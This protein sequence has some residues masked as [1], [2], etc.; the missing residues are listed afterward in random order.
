MLVILIDD[1]GFGASSAFGGPCHTPTAERLAAGGLKFTPLPHHGAVLADPPGAADRPQPPLGGHGRHHRDGDLRAGQQ[2]GCAPRSKAPLAEIL[3]L[4]G[5]STAQFGKCHEVPT[6][7]TSP[8][9]P[10]H[11]W[12]TGSGFEYFYGFVGGEANQYYPGHLRGT[13]W[14]SS[15]PRRPSRATTS[16]RT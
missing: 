4:N 6:W 15:R 8:M 11:Q 7:E 5:Y 12:P 10:F 2:H 1:V 9:G 3:K 14:R 13:R 16:R